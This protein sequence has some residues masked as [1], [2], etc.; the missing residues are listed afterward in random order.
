MILALLKIFCKPWLG[1]WVQ[2]KLDVRKENGRGQVQP[3]NQ[4]I[5]W[6]SEPWS[7]PWFMAKWTDHSLYQGGHFYDR[8]LSTLWNVF[9]WLNFRL[10]INSGGNVES[11]GGLSR[12][13]LV[14][15]LFSLAASERAIRPPRPMSLFRRSS[16][17][18]RQV[19]KGQIIIG[20]PHWS[21]SFGHWLTH[22]KVQHLVSGSTT[23]ECNI[24]S[25]VE[26]H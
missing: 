12:S 20:V 9:L 26:P 16:L 21:V 5:V 6:Q 4:M 11:R 2:S 24:W 19:T 1:C 13:S 14:S 3:M 22:I 10:T 8:L 7:G 25:R 18:S 23:F 17:K 15:D